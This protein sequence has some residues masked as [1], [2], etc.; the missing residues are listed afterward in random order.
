M[1]ITNIRTAPKASVAAPLFTSDEVQRQLLGAT[2]DFS[3]SVIYFGRG[4]RNK[5]H[6]HTSDQLLIVTEGRGIIATEH[7]KREVGVGDVA[8][9]PTGEKH[10]HGA[11]DDGGPFAHISILLKGSTHEQFEP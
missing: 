2:N 7:E 3:F 11:M 1:E 6:A 5:L 9:I 4:V 10:W 8:V